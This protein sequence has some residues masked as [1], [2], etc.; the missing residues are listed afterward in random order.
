MDESEAEFDYLSVDDILTLHEVIVENSDETEPG[1]SARGSLEYTAEHI[2]EG[3][4]GQQPSTLHEK[5]F[6]LLRLVVANHPFVDGNKRT[7]L[8]SAV[9]FYALNGYDLDYGPE[10]KDV[11]KRFATNEASVDRSAVI[12]YL[13]AHT[14]ELPDEYE[15]TYQVLSDLAVSRG[16]EREN[17]GND[18]ESGETTK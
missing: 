15:E 18:Y 5:A 1:I 9:A 16:F 7:A 17:K 8:V 4:F 14:A 12:E 3:Y 13:E 6:P 10:M 11:L 2:R